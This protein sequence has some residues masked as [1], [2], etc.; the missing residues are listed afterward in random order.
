MYRTLADQRQFG[1]KVV[2]ALNWLLPLVVGGAAFAIGEPWLQL[3]I[4]GLIVAGASTL[5][6]RFDSRGLA[7]RLCASVALMAQVSLLVASLR[8]HAWQIDMHMT[9]FAALAVLTIFCDWRAIL[10]G[11]ATV[12]LHHLTLNFILPAAV[13]PGGGDFWR[14]VVHAV[15]LVSEAVLLM[16][17]ARNISKTLEE[18]LQ[19]Q[20]AEADA[21][22]AEQKAASER[23]ALQQRIGEEQSKVVFT[24]AS[25]LSRMAKGDL[26][27]QIDEHFSDE[28][29]QLKRDFNAALKQLQSAMSVVVA[30]V[31]SIKTSAGEI[32][33]AADDLSQ[34][35]ERQA[36]SLE[37][38][39]TALDEIT[40]TVQRSAENARGADS[41]VTSTREKA[42][43]GGLV[44]REA[45]DAMNAIDQSARQISRIVGVIDEIAFQTSLLALNAGVE[46]ARAGD[47]GK[48]FAVVAQE[49]RTLAQRAAEAAREIKVLIESSSA[50]VEM[51][52]SLVNRTGEEFDGIAVQIGA[53]SA[54]MSELAQSAQ[55]QS[56]SLAQ[57]NS[58]MNDMDRATQQNAAM[59]EESTAATQSLA[60]EAAD[61][62]ELVNRF[63]LNEGPA[64]RR[65]AA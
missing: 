13:F 31:D 2:T 20:L 11:A 4:A 41:A 35:T 58:A 42:K 40:A 21:R 26:T 43:K 18:V 14:V 50:H 48:G 45:I 34:R 32:G 60:N 9:Y 36:A 56:A 49:V 7:G 57:V 16:W 39:A 10:A 5:V 65:A 12:A 24:L 30:N 6:L 64:K 52:V 53:V 19:A 22:A 46:A 1:A 38:T 59:V 25:G 37:E 29:A 27:A 55:E 17:V 61:L 54:L 8:G 44:V 3:A 23:A 51:G 15:I 62:A 33:H 28:Y 63:K 47:T